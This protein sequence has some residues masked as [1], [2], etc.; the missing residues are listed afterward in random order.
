MVSLYSLLK[1]F[2]LDAIERGEIA[3]KYHL[4]LS[5]QEDSIAD[6]VFW[7]CDSTTFSR[8]H[9]LIMSALSLIRNNYIVLTN[10]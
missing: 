1:G 10:H 6:P 7:N 8:S 3:I 4:L 5:N 9:S 2:C